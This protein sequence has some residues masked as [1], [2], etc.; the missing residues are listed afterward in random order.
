MPTAH[1]LAQTSCAAALLC[2]C[3]ATATAAEPQATAPAQSTAS[4][5]C[6]QVEMHNVRPQQGFVMVAAYA[7]AASFGKTSSTQLKLAA[8]D[9]VMRFV[10]CG[11]SGDTVALTAFQDLDADG[12]LGRNPIGIP[13]EPWGASGTPGAFGP[14][15]E[16][17]RVKLD[18]TPVVVKLSQ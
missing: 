12:K 14:T 7:D 8:G 4:P 5:G 11:L 3:I 18:G 17:G 13:S 15:W 10:M 2:S 1:F 6:V 9:A 16:T